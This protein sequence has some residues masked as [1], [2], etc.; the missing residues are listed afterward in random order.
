MD[1]SHVSL[2]QKVCPVCGVT[3]DS[4]AILL[5]RRLRQSMER[6]TITGWDLCPDHQA[7]Y[8]EGF[9]ALVECDEAKGSGN[10]PDEVWRTGPI[11]HIKQEAFDRV[12]DIPSTS[13]DGTMMPFMWIAADVTKILTDMSPQVH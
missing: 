7:K 1:K 12:F 8:D 6:T 4:G 3:F 11:V 10:K 13:G 2:E 9:I 5:D